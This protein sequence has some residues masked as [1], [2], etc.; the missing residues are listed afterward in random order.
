MDTS[1]SHVLHTQ[2][3]SIA[4]Q[5]LIIGWLIVVVFL[6]RLTP[7]FV[8]PLARGAIIVWSC[9]SVPLAVATWAW[10]WINGRHIK[11]LAVSITLWCAA[12]SVGDQLLA[13]SGTT[14]ADAVELSLLLVASGLCA[15]N[16]SAVLRRS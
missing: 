4:N 1:L 13:T 7:V 14:L 5:L 3:R 2:R 6:L 8:N 9:V 16:I 10:Q 15:V 11:W 12:A